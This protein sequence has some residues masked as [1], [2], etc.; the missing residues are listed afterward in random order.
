M[1]T[2]ETLALRLVDSGFDTFGGLYAAEDGCA[3]LVIASE[4]SL[5]RW[6]KTGEGP[7]W[8]MT[9]RVLYPLESIAAWLNA[10]GLRANNFET[11]PQVAASVLPDSRIT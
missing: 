7:H 10:G 1:F 6:R 4:R 2:A 3:H 11:W 9:S 5:R 8:I